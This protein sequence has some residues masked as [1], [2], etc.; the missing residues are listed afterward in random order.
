MNYSHA[1]YLLLLALGIS[2]LWTAGSI[3]RPDQSVHQYTAF[4]VTREDGELVLT[5][6]DTGEERRGADVLDTNVDENIVCLPRETRE[7]DLFL[8]D[9]DGDVNATRYRSEYRYVYTNDG[10]YRLTSP[11]F[12]EFE[13]ERT[14]SSDVFAALALDSARLTNTERD[15]LEDGKTTTTKSVPHSNRLVVHDGQYYTILET[16]IKVHDDSVTFCTGNGDFCDRADR[17]RW[18]EWVPVIGLGILGTLGTIVGG[19]GLLR[20]YRSDELDE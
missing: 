3:D 5:D 15:V 18:L 6:E 19:W 17:V 10:F 20:E 11:G 2:V 14:D 7:C 12:G 13:Y 4:E 16:G 9:I 1:V 8:E